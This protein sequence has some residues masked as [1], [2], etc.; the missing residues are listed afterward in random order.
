MCGYYIHVVCFVMYITLERTVR[1]VRSKVLT[2]LICYEVAILHNLNTFTLTQ[3]T[4][5]DLENLKDNQ[6]KEVNDTM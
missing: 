1:A 6:E 3:G 2:Y 4:V 5:K